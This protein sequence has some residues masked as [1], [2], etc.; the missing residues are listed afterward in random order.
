MKSKL[1]FLC[2]FIGGSLHS[3]PTQ[4][5]ANKNIIVAIIDTGVDVSHPM[6]RDHLWTNPEYRLNGKGPAR[7]LHGWNFISDN[8]DISDNHGHGTH[9]A[10]IIL[11]QSQTTQVKFM[12]LKYYD[13]KQKNSNN[14]QNTIEAIHYAIEKNADIINYSGGGENKSLLEEQAIQEAQKKGILFVAAAG[15]EGRNTDSRGYYPAGYHLPNIISV[16]A[17]DS[18]QRLLNSSNFGSQSV[19][20]AAPGKDIFSSLPGGRFGL[21]TGTSQATAWVSGLAVSLK[22]NADR[23]LRAEELK[24]VIENIANETVHNPHNAP[25]RAKLSTISLANIWKE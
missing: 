12:I 9:I 22:A 19:D 8:E 20:I 16:A 3:T 15:N 10:G 1:L 21:M 13:P 2:L 24:K 14:L 6:I 5:H 11:Q 4:A 25:I 7:G 18:Q 17:L 23:D